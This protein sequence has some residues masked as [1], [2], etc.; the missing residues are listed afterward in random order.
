M[1]C[2]QTA[3]R[4]SRDPP[5]LAEGSPLVGARSRVS[6]STETVRAARAAPSMNRALRVFRM[7]SSSRPVRR[8]NPESPPGCVLSTD[9]SPPAPVP[10]VAFDGRDCR[11][12]PG[13]DANRGAWGIGGRT[14]R[15]CPRTGELLAAAQQRRLWEPAAAQRPPFARILQVDLS[16]ATGTYWRDILCGVTVYAHLRHCLCARGSAEK[17]SP[18]M[19][20]APNG[21]TR[22][23]R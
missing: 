19:R 14:R 5:Q 15:R 22:P 18:F 16:G 23:W 17:A 12:F 4:G 1:I 9:P 6:T 2:V 3:G 8:A 11:T 21:G 20:N 10:D 13:S 7:S